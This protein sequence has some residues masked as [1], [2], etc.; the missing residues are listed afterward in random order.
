MRDE[1]AV[2]SIVSLFVSAAMAQS[3]RV[4]ICHIPPGNP[5]NAHTITISENAVQSHLDHGDS[6][7]E[8]GEHSHS[9]SIYDATQRI[10]LILRGPGIPA[11]HVVDEVV[12][13]VDVFP[14]ALDGLGLDA[15]P[16]TIQGTS[17]F[18][19][20]HGMADGWEGR[21]YSM[22]P[23]EYIGR[24]APGYGTDPP[25]LAVREGDWKLVRRRDSAP[26]LF[27]LGTDPT[28]KVDVA[29]EHPEIVAAL[30]EALDEWIGALEPP[31]GAAPVDAETLEFLRGLGYVAGEEEE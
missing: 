13:L 27:D 30:D 21:A 2:C 1:L 7:G 18:P 16:G 3:V 5:A 6:L 12:E 28:E 24:S 17:L 8:H 25:A 29:S 9:F 14:T 20:M 22:V 31:Q 19:L 15:P 10:P 4:E 23:T 26:E 11:G